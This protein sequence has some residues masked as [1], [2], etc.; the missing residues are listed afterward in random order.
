MFNAIKYCISIE[1]LDS[2]NST[3]SFKGSWEA[4]VA[5]YCD[6]VTQLTLYY[7]VCLLRSLSLPWIPC[8]IHT[9]LTIFVLVSSYN[10]DLLHYLT[11][12][13]E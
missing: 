3:R 5:L 11:Y 12:F 10:R 9:I 1:V 4:V 2:V 7:H 13:I 6:A 8:A